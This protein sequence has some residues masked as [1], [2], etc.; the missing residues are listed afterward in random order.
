MLLEKSYI[1]GWTLNG[2]GKLDVKGNE[3]VYTAPSA[4][5]ANKTATITVELNVQG[6][7]VLLISTI[8]I[9]E[10]GIEISI[11]GGPWETWTGM[12]TK[13]PEFNKYSLGSLRTSSD[14]PQIVFMW[15]MTGQKA[16]VMY[17]WSAFGEDESHVVFEYATPDLQKIYASFYEDVNHE[18]RNS[19]GMIMVE[20]MEKNG[21][22]YL[23]GSFAINQAGVTN[24]GEGQVGISNIFGTFKV[25]R[26]W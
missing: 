25:Q 5:A 18:V 13:V 9:L 8:F 4:P 23:V 3:A 10:D 11:D 21:K 17:D 14:I 20:E 24:A 15:P 12:A 2:P 6:I 22:K 7:Q 1:V 16:N 26:S 19:G